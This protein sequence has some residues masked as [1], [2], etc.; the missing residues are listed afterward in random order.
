MSSW[1]DFERAKSLRPADISDIAQQLSAASAFL[2]QLTQG[3]GRQTS[4]QLDRARAVLSEAAHA[5]TRTLETT[6]SSRSFSP[7]A[8]ASLSDISSGGARIETCS[9]GNACL[10]RAL[11]DARSSRRR[12][13]NRALDRPSSLGGQ[14]HQG[15][16]KRREK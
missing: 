12:A 6:W 10:A 11:G 7:R 15:N 3:F 5:L 9:F 4:S 13:L 8:W 1:I 2:G 16:Q 14:G